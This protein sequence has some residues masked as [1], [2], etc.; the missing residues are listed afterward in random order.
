MSF[1]DI[2]ELQ[3]IDIERLSSQVKDPNSKVFKLYFSEEV[4]EE[5]EEEVEDEEVEDE[6]TSNKDEL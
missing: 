2:T 4:E 3:A 6:E 1:F 5:E